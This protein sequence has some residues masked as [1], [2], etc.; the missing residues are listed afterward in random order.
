MRHLSGR[1]L[2]A[3]GGAFLLIAA[4][5]AVRVAVMEEMIPSAASAGPFTGNPVPSVEEH[6]A[7]ALA[8]EEAGDVGEALSYYRAAAVLDPR[9]VDRL[10]P[11]F[12]GT[13]FEGKLKNWLADMRSGRITAGPSAAQDAA[14]LFR[15][16]Y[17]GCG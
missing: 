7:A 6:V 5:A 4:A 9:C 3:L 15:R 16:M 13:G 17:G 8:A 14:Y 10:S 11:M 12:L 2:T 1:K